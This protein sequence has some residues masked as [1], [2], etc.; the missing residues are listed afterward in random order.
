VFFRGTV[1][2]VYKDD[3]GRSRAAYT[4]VVQNQ[5]EQGEPLVE[6]TLAPG[7]QRDVN[8]Q[9]LYPPDATPPQVLTISTGG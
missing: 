9:F 8:V 6:V 5:G 1:L 7:E 2:F 4:Y 3:D